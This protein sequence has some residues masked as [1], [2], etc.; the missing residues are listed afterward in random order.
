[1]DNIVDNAFHKW[2]GNRSMQKVVLEGDELRPKAVLEEGDEQRPGVVSVA[3][4]RRVES[5]VRGRRPS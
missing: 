5:C 1:M 2:S 3:R 4:V